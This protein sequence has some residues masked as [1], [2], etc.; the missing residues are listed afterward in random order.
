QTLVALAY[1][2]MALTAT[3]TA[4]HSVATAVVVANVGTYV[5]NLVPVLVR[6][7][8][9]YLLADLLGTPR[10]ASDGALALGSLAVPGVSA[11]RGAKLWV[12]RLY[13]A[14]ALGFRLFLL[15][16]GVGFIYD[17]LG[18]KVGKAAA[19]F[20]AALAVR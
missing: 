17:F 12:L 4:V 10:L 9:Y 3:G 6:L 8:G 16:A 15:L 18:G 13:G 5:V 20:L 19:F 14:A 11:E 2:V 1:P 7:D